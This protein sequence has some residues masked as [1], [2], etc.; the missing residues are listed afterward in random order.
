MVRMQ[1]FVEEQ[2]AI[3]MTRLILAHG[4]LGEGTFA[5]LQGRIR[6]AENG[7]GMASGIA[8]D[9]GLEYVRTL[10]MDDLGQMARNALDNDSLRERRDQLRSF[11]NADLII[12]T[13]DGADD[14]VRRHRN[15]LHR[16]PPRDRPGGK[17]RRTADR[18]HRSARCPRCRQRP[19]R[20][21]RG[22]P[23]RAGPR[24]LAP[25]RRPHAPA[26][27]TAPASCCPHRLTQSSSARS[28]ASA[29]MGKVESVNS[30]RLRKNALNAPHSLIARVNVP[31]CI[32]LNH[33]QMNDDIASTDQEIGRS[34]FHSD[35]TIQVAAGIS[36]AGFYFERKRILAN[37][38]HS[39]LTVFQ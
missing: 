6:P 29:L 38:R 27:M 7:Y 9:M 4:P 1:R 31:Q 30:K 15:I 39:N 19:K 5:A 23:D 33:L 36:F 8:E 26:G 10:S 24:L 2:T 32:P 12:E 35:N 17:E 21:V 28:R 25:P 22:A 13:K 18:V 14:Q 20:Q 16:R 34:V 11:R 3:S 37:V